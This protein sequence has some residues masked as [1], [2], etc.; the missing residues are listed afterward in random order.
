M[1]LADD[2]VFLLEVY[3]HELK[4]NPIWFTKM[5]E[6]G[7]L[8]RRTIS[9]LEDRLYD[10]GLLDRAWENVENKW[11]YVYHTS[12]EIKLL[13]NQILETMVCDH[14]GEPVILGVDSFYCEKEGCKTR[15]VNYKTW[16]MEV[17]N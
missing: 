13:L 17:K 7:K 12:E 14:C 8:D 16:S 3:T 4:E 6:I 5:V 10:L 15:A 2:L 9:K 1:K 11:T